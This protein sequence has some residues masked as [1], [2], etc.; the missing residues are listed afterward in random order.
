MIDEFMIEKVI[1]PEDIGS[2]KQEFHKA[3]IKHEYGESE[4]NRCWMARE[5]CILAL[6][7]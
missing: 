2:E 6:S 7:S 4:L 5:K 1:R 3:F